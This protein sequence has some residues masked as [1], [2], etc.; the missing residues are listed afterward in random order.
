MEDDAMDARDRQAIEELFGKL[1]EVE[2]RSPT[3]DRDAEALIRDFIARQPGAP[4]YMAQTI[5]AQEQALIAAQERLEQGEQRGSG[6]FLSEIFGPGPGRDGGRR[7]RGPR[8]REPGA[9]MLPPGASPWGRPSFLGGAMQ[10]ALGVAGGV[11]LGSFMADLLM[12]DHAMAGEPAAGA[13][14]AGA[15]TADQDMADAGPGDDDLGGG[16]F[17]G[18]DFGGGDL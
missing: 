5:I 10:T 13:H 14:D 4:Y 11:V 18:G 12:P 2:R 1:R 3:R 9:R 15:D 17:G 7:E 16:D 8:D 6:G